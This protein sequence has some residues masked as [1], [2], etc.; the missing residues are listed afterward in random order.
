[1]ATLPQWTK[2]LDDDFVNTWYEIRAFV[3]DNVLDATVFTAALRNFGC[4]ETQVGS[5]IVTDTIGYGEK[6]TQRFDRGTV[7]TQEVK[8]LDTMAEWNW[9]FFQSDANRSLV[10]DAKNTGKF[11]I[12]SYIS[13]RLEAARDALVQDTEKYFTQWGGAY[14]APKQPNGL[15]DITPLA[16]A[17]AA[18]TAPFSDT[19]NISETQA[20]GTNNGKIN[21]TNAWWRNWVMYDDA[22]AAD[23]T[24]IAGPTNEPY[25]L[26]F[27]VDLRHMFNKIRANQEAPNF[28]LC[29]QDIYEAYEDEAQDKQ[30]IVQSAFTKTAI[31]L[32]FDAFTFK[33][34][35]MAYSSKLS[36]TLHVHLLN[37]NHIKVTYNPN[38]WFDMTSWK[39]S[40]NQH[41][42]VAYIVCMTTG[43]RTPQP[44]RHGSMEYAS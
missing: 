21:R 28:I 32:G 26:N 1:M 27:V 4:F 13:R 40:P 11:Q 9:R 15:Y 34:A 23:S 36:G 19:E 22:T 12:K 5:D 2:Y 33:G 30:T 3:I 42:R 7:L 38:L 10:D 37:M 20:T 29:D 6:A 17:E 39:E 41:E 14:N 16:T 43:L 8:D 25:A 44:R 35:T 24:L 31:D 18:A